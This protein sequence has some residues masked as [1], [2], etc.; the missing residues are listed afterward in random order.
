MFGKG[1]SARVADGFLIAL[2]GAAL[3]GRAGHVLLNWDYFAF[4]QDEVYR[5]DLGGIDWH[6][7][8]FGALI[9]LW[10]GARLRRFDFNRTLAWCAPLVGL[11]GL[12]V[13]RMC[14]GVGCAAGNEVD[15]LARYPALIVAELP[16][17]YGII[18]PRWNTPLMGMAGALIALVAGLIALR[19]KSG[20]RGFW[21][22]LALMGLIMLLI[23]AF[24]PISALERAL[25]AAVFGASSLIALISR[26]RS[27]SAG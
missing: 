20:A 16:D 2:G 10:F 8:V 7:A 18:A 3:L 22:T 1:Q 23:G 21:L 13:W 5:L 12:L 9:G 19:R 24:R 15:T 25:D 6:F 11:I 26:A 27:Q 4:H 14:A 17:R